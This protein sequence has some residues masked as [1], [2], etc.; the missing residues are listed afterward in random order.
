MSRPHSGPGV[1]PVRTPGPVPLRRSA[2]PARH[3]ARAARPLGIRA[4][5]ARTAIVA[6]LNRWWRH[7][8]AAVWGPPGAA[9]VGGAIGVA[10]DGLVAGAV[11]AAYGAAGI[12]LARGWAARRAERRAR[13]IASDAVLGLAADLRAGLA[14]GPAWRA[15]EEMLRR[16]ETDLLPT[17]RGDRHRKSAGGAA[18][19]VAL[20]AQRMVAATALAEA[21]GA[22]LADVLERL[23]THLRAVDRARAVAS[24]QAAGAR[25]SAALLALM[26]LA[27]IGLG[28]AVGVDPWRVL[29]HTPA[30][31]VALGLAV[32]LQ[33]VGV[34]WTARLADTEAES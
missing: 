30:G 17:W 31:A 33:L 10:L 27:G 8:R 34:A 14:L 13:R 12:V 3:S 26:P 20:V 32:A 24:S 4:R 28:I 23:D 15:A 21:C 22:P 19:P 16:A 2:S 25:A 6:T 5:T 11:L 18:G 9:M 7:R 1:F 29:L